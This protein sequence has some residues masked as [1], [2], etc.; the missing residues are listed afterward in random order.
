MHIKI[1]NNISDKLEMVSIH[2]METIIAAS[3]QVFP[4]IK[5][6]VALAAP[7]LFGGQTKFIALHDAL[8]SESQK[9]GEHFKVL[10]EADMD[11]AVNA[12]LRGIQVR[13]QLKNSANGAWRKD[14]EFAL[15]RAQDGY[16][17]VS[18][19]EQ[20]IRCY[21]IMCICFLALREPNEAFA[22]ILYSTE[23]LLKNKYVNSSLS[24]LTKTLQ[25][26]RKKL[27]T[28]DNAL[29][30]L[31]FS[32]VC[33]T[34]RA[35]SQDKDW[36]HKNREEFRRLFRGNK[37]LKQ[38]TNP[39]LFQDWKRLQVTTSSGWRIF[40]S[41][42]RSNDIIRFRAILTDLAQSDSTGMYRLGDII[43]VVDSA[44]HRKVVSG[45]NN[46]HWFMS[47]VT[48][49]KKATTPLF[50][51]S[52]TTIKKATTPLFMSPVTTIKKATA[53]LFLLAAFGLTSTTGRRRLQ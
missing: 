50:M 7:H 41:S 46:Y 51:S 17:R 13:R 15:E 5:K 42:R 29:L 3:E 32:R 44:G 48:T 47:S 22:S 30:S 34:I 8:L 40:R 33:G 39:E 36:T 4:P 49:I 18:L 16:Y 26:P 14:L 1:P 25:R 10:R 27:S 53:P 37:H 23:T 35:C 9:V 24:S 52:V 6:A 45:T 19:P 21:E 28:A 20:K 43:S 38:A 11:T 2:A 12:Y 31:L